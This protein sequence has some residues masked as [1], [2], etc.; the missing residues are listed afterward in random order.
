MKQLAKVI[1]ALLNRGHLN[2]E[3]GLGPSTQ[4]DDFLAC[5]SMIGVKPPQ[6]HADFFEFFDEV[7]PMG[8]KAPVEHDARPQRTKGA[9]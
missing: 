1:R 7:D 5:P 9:E 2:V 3:R 8:W 4:T 6:G